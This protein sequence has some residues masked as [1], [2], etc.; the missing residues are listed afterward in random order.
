MFNEKEVIVNNPTTEHIEVINLENHSITEVP[1]DY[2]F[3]NTS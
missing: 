2:F 1:H 3:P